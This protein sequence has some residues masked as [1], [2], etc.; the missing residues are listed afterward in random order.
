VLPGNHR[1]GDRRVAVDPPQEA[2]AS[3]QRNYCG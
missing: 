1:P 3:L 2:L